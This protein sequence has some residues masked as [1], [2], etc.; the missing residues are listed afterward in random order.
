V[1]Q[2]AV[3]LRTVMSPRQIPYNEA[4]AIRKDG[5]LDVDALRVAFNALVARHDA[6]H[7]TFD[8]VDGTPVQRVVTPPNY[9]LPL[10]DLGDLEP[11]EAERRAV[12]AVAETARVP[13]DLRCGPLVRPR[14]VRFSPDHHRLYLAMHHIV[15]DGVSVTRTV[16]SE[17]VALYDTCRGAPALGEPAAG[18]ADYARWEQDWIARPR[19]RHR[20]EHWR[21][22]LQALPPPSLP[23]DR[24]RPATA[25]ARGGAVGL[26]IGAQDVARLRAVAQEAGATLFQILAATWAALLARHLPS[27][28]V[29]FA[30]PADLR[31]RPEFQGLVGYCLTPLVLRVDT[32]GEPTLRDLLGRLRDE[33]LDGLDNLVPFE[34]IVR[35]LRPSS[36]SANPVFQTLIVLEPATVS[37]DHDWSLHQI[38]APLADA[39]GAAKLDLELQL[40]ER[41]DGT[42]TGR[43]IYDRDLFDRASAEALSD[44]WVRLTT[45]AAA[46]PE[47]SVVRLPLLSAAEER[48][49]LVEWNAT[50][51]RR[52]PHRPDQAS[53]DVARRLLG[54]PEL[55]PGALG[56]AALDLAAALAEGL[57]IGPDDAA[58]VLAHP[59]S[60]VP[61]S[62]VWMPLL[63]GARVIVAP[64]ELAGD[65]RRLSRL[66][67]QDGI[68]L[69]H[70]APSEWARLLQTG[71]RR[72][73]ALKALSGGEPLTA[74]LAERILGRFR[75]LWHGYGSA[76]TG[77]YCLLGRVQNPSD[78]TLG[79]PL[80]NVRAHVIDAYDQL[81]PV[82]V[83]GDLA[84]AGDAVAAALRSGVLEPAACIGDLF[85]GGPALRTGDRVRRRADGRLALMPA[86]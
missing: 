24:P 55:P 2:E 41:L 45:A 1:A 35:E 30:T 70:A 68:T 77:G 11:E 6:W 82:G 19:V 46:A 31:R 72:P 38:D 76:R 52:P 29:V 13:Y 74:D 58:L 60:R 51:T 56:A 59:L 63:A 62:A 80:A 15:F 5:P 57:T 14:L 85:G 48:R 50:A 16:L 44:H 27:D 37:H 10:L 66:M 9:D 67:A 3:W 86:A 21:G 47:R 23:L 39:V 65:G 54:A 28:D 32:A 4:V 79:R 36:S 7:T 33:V 49:Q 8:V 84:I 20:M 78:V 34:R 12:A 40:D 18:Y 64:P 69:L 25:R 75:G 83:G 26:A 42:L 22:R 17:L 43:L 73:R 71:L 81:V 53:R 61:T